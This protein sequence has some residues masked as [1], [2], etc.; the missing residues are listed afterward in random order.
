[1]TKEYLIGPLSTAELA[2]EYMLGGR[3]T[4]TIRSTRTGTRYTFKMVKI[5]QSDN[6]LLIY[7]Y[8]GEGEGTRKLGTFNKERGLRV[9]TGNPHF[10]QFS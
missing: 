1:M 4:F 3:A 7:L 9:L 2:Q 8:P 6:W 5:K 10:K